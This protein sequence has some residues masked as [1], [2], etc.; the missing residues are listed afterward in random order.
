MLAGK[1]FFYHNTFADH[2]QIGRHRGIPP[3]QR[4]HRW[5]KLPASSSRH[6]YSRTIFGQPAT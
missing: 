3:F 2:A 6:H 4:E 1:L 5:R